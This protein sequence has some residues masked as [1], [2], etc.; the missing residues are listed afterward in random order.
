MIPIR[1][2][3]Y[4]DYHDLNLDWL[5]RQMQIWEVDLEEL[6]RRVKVLE[7]W[8]T[9]TVDPDL[10]DIKLT[11]IDIQG[12][13][14][15]LDDRLTIVEGDVT[16]N[17]NRIQNLKDNSFV[18]W[19][20]FFTSPSSHIEFRKGSADGEIIT[21]IY[22]IIKAAKCVNNPS[23]GYNNVR[24]IVA[25]SGN[26]TAISATYK[27]D[28]PSGHPDTYRVY[29]YCVD[30]M[31]VRFLNEYY[32][33]FEVDTSNN[34]TSPYKGGISGNLVSDFGN[35]KFS[36]ADIFVSNTDPN[37]NTDYP[38]YVEKTYSGSGLTS[39]NIMEAYF[40]N[41][42][43]MLTYSEVIGDFIETGTNLFRV[44]F[45]RALTSGEEFTLNFTIIH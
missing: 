43:D 37:T 39:D 24:F 3:P 44:Y 25:E 7:D 33:Y 45:T 16:I 21:D 32:I 40:L 29:L 30:Q 2:F 12:D 11:I 13:I 15:N 36:D 20:K 35:I 4:T 38:Y 8:R 9:D 31:H 10:R 5:L 26:D 14:R 18:V 28:I 23:Y 27:I 17:K 41:F 42:A 1:N 34:V 22:D 6:K 19:V